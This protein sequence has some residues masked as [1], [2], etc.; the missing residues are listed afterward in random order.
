MSSTGTSTTSVSGGSTRTLRTM[1][2]VSMF[3][4]AG[5][6]LV[7]TAQAQGRVNAVLSHG[8]LAAQPVFLGSGF[9]ALNLVNQE[10][11]TR[12]FTV[13]RLRNGATLASFEAANQALA[14]AKGAGRGAYDA[15]AQLDETAAALAGLSVGK[16]S[17]KTMLVNFT[18]GTYVLAAGDKNGDNA[19]YTAFEVVGSDGTAAAGPQVPNVVHFSDTS[20]D[21]PRHV[22]TGTTLWRVSNTG[23]EPHVAEF[24]RLLPGRTTQDLLAYLRGESTARKPFDSTANI[25]MVAQGETVYVPVDFKDGDWVAIC[26]V[27]DQD[28][29]ALTHVMNGMI[30]EFQVY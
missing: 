1:L 14:E 28:D 29:P 21:F 23:S 2:L 16:Y 17:S 13:Y 15:I 27:S 30:S 19:V 8:A 26:F 11:S 20:F 6:L 22:T 12:Y 9:S 4:L 10:G 7:G 3:A 24:Y 18:R 5:V 25:G